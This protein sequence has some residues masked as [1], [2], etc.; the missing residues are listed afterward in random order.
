MHLR[1]LLHICI[2]RWRSVVAS[3]ALNQLSTDRISDTYAAHNPRLQLKLLGEVATAQG[4]L[5]HSW[6]SATHVFGGTKRCTCCLLYTFA[7]Q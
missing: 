4:Q 7:F 1:S 5:L 2:W 6:S 3:L